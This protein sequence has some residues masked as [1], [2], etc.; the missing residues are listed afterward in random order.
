MS[1]I[2]VIV[3]I[4]LAPFVAGYLGALMERSGVSIGRPAYLLRLVVFWGAVYVVS[5]YGGA[6]VFAL[7]MGGWGPRT[8]A[9]AVGLGAFQCVAFWYTGLLMARRLNDIGTSR[10]RW[11]A[12]L[13]GFPIIGL[14]VPL[15]LGFLPPAG[16]GRSK[17]EVG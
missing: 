11:L 2:I 7:G 9:V 3:V 8:L 6:Y 10:Y 15:V 14:L 16:S 1:Q 17:A 5:Y 13:T 4:I 12:A